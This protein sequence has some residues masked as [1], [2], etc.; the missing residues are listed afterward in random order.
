MHRQQLRAR[1]T[2][3]NIADMLP[4]PDD[5][6]YWRQPDYI[7]VGNIKDLHAQDQDY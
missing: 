1:D 6:Q 3:T 2:E 4:Q 7:L 5:S